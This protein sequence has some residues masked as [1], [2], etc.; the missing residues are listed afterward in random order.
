MTNYRIKLKEVRKEKKIS[1]TELA[2]MINS[3][4]R[5]ISEYENGV[6]NP[7]LER[8]VQL[9]QMLDV[10]LDELIEFKR[11]QHKLSEE[12]NNEK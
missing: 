10:S 8:L 11:I 12:L 4:Q 3:D 6:S 2:K 5:V 1:Q 7:S 9:A